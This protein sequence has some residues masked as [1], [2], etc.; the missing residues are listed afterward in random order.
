MNDPID[1][2]TKRSAHRQRLRDD[3]PDVVVV[4]PVDA[5]LARTL[6]DVEEVLLIADLVDVDE[7]LPAALGGRDAADAVGALA[8]LTASFRSEEDDPHVQPL[9]P[10]GH[11]ELVALC[12]ARLG[13]DAR[14]RITEAVDCLAA[15][16]TS[17]SNP[18]LDEALSDYAG[19]PRAARA[20]VERAERLSALLTLPWDDDVDALAA[21]LAGDGPKRRVVLTNDE[22]DAYRRVTER[23]LG[24]WHA[25]DPLERFV[26]RA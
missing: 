3:S 25:G 9:A 22:Y 17:T 4:L 26:Y 24:S 15:T 23:I 11:Y 14:D 8:A 19:D 12:V 2:A 5:E 18:A 20:L 7:A 13:R 10:D 16:R 6:G 21:C 1:L